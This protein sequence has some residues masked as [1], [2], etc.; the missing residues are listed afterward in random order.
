VADTATPIRQTSVADDRELRSYRTRRRLARVGLYLLA[1][2]T[3]AVI[4]I[5]LAFSVL[6][7]FRTSQQ[8]AADPVGLP[9]PWVWENYSMLLRSGSFWRQIWNSTLVALLTTLVVLPAASM[10]AFVLARYSFRGRELVYGLFTLGLL[11]PVAVAILPLFIVL[12][13]VGLLSNPLGVALPQAAFGLPISIIIMRPFFRG[14]PQSLQ[15]A[16]RI[17]GCGPLR[18]YWYVMLPLSRPVLSTIAVITIVGSWNAFLLPLLVLIDPNQHT[19]PIGVNN[20]SSQYATDFS[21]VLAYT[22]LSMIPALIFYALAERQIIGGLT[23][24]AVKE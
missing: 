4:V 8:L 23:S 13:Q 3:M 20:I 11:F 12:R 22:T 14:V 5:P 6:G 16:A 21:I 17:D 15:D 2:V 18:F 24:G 1:F 9:N 19:L 10:A 7:G